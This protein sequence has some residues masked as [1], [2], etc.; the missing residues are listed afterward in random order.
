MGYC[1]NSARYIPNH[2]FVLVMNYLYSNYS[3]AASRCDEKLLKIKSIAPDKKEVISHLYK[4]I[5]KIWYLFSIK[6][7]QQYQQ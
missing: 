4:E 3:Q 5:T 7:S 2:I 6:E 1:R